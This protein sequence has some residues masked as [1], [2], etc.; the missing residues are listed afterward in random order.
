MTSFNREIKASCRMNRRQCDG[1]SMKK[2]IKRSGKTVYK[3][4]PHCEK[5]PHLVARRNARE[6][7]RVETVNNAF[8]RLRKHV[9]MDTK[10][11]RLSKVKTLRY[12][13][14]YIKRLTEMI[15]DHDKNFGA[16]CCNF[17]RSVTMVTASTQEQGRL[18]Y[19]SRGINADVSAYGWFSTR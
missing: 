17:G 7:R 9:P 15:D 1:K 5:P 3:H 10:H 6:R 11:K 12:A 14:D 4:V 8:L 13:I 2:R 18:I 16:P 19:S